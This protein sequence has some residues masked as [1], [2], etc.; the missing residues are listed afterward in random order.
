LSA[1]FRGVNTVVV[2]ERAVFYT[3]KEGLPGHCI[4]AGNSNVADN[5][6]N[7]DVS[8]RAQSLAA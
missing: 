6:K 4:S 2:L 8:N 5:T 3:R 7:M 1:T